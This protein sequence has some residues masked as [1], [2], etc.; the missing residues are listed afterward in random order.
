MIYACSIEQQYDH[1][2]TIVM[3]FVAEDYGNR[4]PTVPIVFNVGCPSAV[5][6]EVRFG[7]PGNLGP[8]PTSAIFPQPP[9]RCWGS[10]NL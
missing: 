5:V 8:Y 2:I 6:V 10:F 9:D 4:F 7:G 1:V 3:R